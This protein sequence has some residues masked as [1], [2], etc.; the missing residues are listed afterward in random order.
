MPYRPFPKGTIKKLIQQTSGGNQGVPS[1]ETA[2]EFPDPL[3]EEKAQNIGKQVYNEED[4]QMYVYGLNKA[5]SIPNLDGELD[6]NGVYSLYS[7]RYNVNGYGF[8]ASTKPE[9]A[10]YVFNRYEDN[11][12]ANNAMVEYWQPSESY[13]RDAWLQVELPTHQA[14]FGY[15]IKTSLA[16]PKDWKIFGVNDDG[17]EVELD[18]QKDISTTTWQSEK[19]EMQFKID[20]PQ[21]FKKYKFHCLLG[22]ASYLRIW[23]IRFFDIG[24]WQKLTEYIKRGL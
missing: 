4:G 19:S 23:K 12:S 1:V 11:G 24:E 9:E 6:G 14:F 22:N 18:Y 17:T 16:Q 15:A 13:A 5:S 21:Y 2:L 3:E 8:N 10:V 7:D 20:N